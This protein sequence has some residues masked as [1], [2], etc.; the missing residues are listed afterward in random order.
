MLKIY[1]YPRCVYEMPGYVAEINAYV[2]NFSYQRFGFSAPVL[3]GYTN[4]S[5]DKLE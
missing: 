3:Y 2:G 1:T 4:F 5:S